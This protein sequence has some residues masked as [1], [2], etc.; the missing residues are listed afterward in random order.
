MTCGL[1]NIAEVLSVCTEPLTRYVATLSR[2]GRR[3]DQ[4]VSGKAANGETREGESRQ[5]EG[6]R[7]P[8]GSITG[9]ATLP[10]LCLPE[11]PSFPSPFSFVHSSSFPFPSSTHEFQL[12]SL[13]EALDA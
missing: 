1:V 9:D 4:R 5:C 7:W 13:G 3:W 12:G 8:I 11:A 6:E 10:L 2:L